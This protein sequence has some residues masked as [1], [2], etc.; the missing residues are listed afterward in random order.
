MSKL[1]SWFGRGDRGDGQN[2]RH[3]LDGQRVRLSSA[4]VADERDGVVV[5]REP[6]AELRKFVCRIEA[7]DNPDVLP[8]AFSSENPVISWGEPEVLL[9]EEGAADFSRLAELGAILFNHNPNQIVGTPENVRLDSDRVGRLDLRWGSTEMATE[10]R[11]EVADGSLRG[12]SVGWLPLE[13]VYFKTDGVFNGRE[14]PAGTWLASKWQA[15]EA[16][17]TPVPKDSWVGLGRGEN[18]QIGEQEMNRKVTLVRVWK[19]AAGQEH[20]VGE[21]VTVDD[22]VF[23][24]LTEG[25]DPLGVEF[26]DGAPAPDQTRAS[27][28]TIPA[29][30]VVRAVPPQSQPVA[31]PGTTQDP[32]R[33]A[34]ADER[35]RVAA[36][37][38]I[39]ERHGVDSANA[40]RDGW[41]ASQMREFVLETLETRNPPAGHNPIEVTQ[42]GR[43]SYA[44]AA[45]IGLRVRAGTQTT[46]EER[47]EFGGVEI[48]NYSLMRMAEESLVRAGIAVPSNPRDIP[49]RALEGPTLR[50]FDLGARGAGEA[51]TVGT[52][53]FPFILADVANKEMLAGAGMAKNTYTLW[54]KIGSGTDFKA[55]KRLKLSQAGDLEEVTEKEGYSMTKF[56]EQQESLTIVV[57]GKAFNLSRQ[58][59][60]NDDLSAF[61]EVPRAL[62]MRAAYK[63]NIL[64]V[65]KLLANAAMSDGTALFHADH[66]NLSAS[67]DYALSTVAK[68]R[69]GI[70][71]MAKMLALQTAMQ[72]PDLADE[73]DIGV[74]SSLAVIIVPWTGYINAKAAIGS[75][76]FGDDA[77]GTN[78]LKDL[79]FAIHPERLLEHP[80]LTGYS[81]TG[82]Y[83]FASPAASPVMEVAFLNGQAAPYLEETTNTGTAADGRIMK[84]RL[85]CIAGPVDW[86]G[87]IKEAGA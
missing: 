29:V 43:M 56:S 3:G 33:A 75:T 63:P 15:L 81:T 48:A 14:Y 31:D 42:D 69:A 52:S 54:C 79:G 64:A 24:T 40:V 44:R 25:A 59:I 18:I 58:A 73:V 84:V 85:D 16:S 46:V 47:R 71:N 32:V 67:S 50:T 39:G 4:A 83:G 65:T 1:F 36:L 27:E 28:P 82:Y 6:A 2:G 35:V 57:W 22:T 38:A 8:L 9:H 10:R 53:D 5:Y 76:N 80:L 26:K 21:V 13:W 77:E 20:R 23:A 12:V 66:N 68:A 45:S 60:V 86:R 19:D 62:G 51:I 87:A 41:S 17:L 61:T 37:H 55:M 74:D 49:A 72:H 30:T 78:P 34:I 70:Q 11:T 7:G